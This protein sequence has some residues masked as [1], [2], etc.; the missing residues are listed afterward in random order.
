MKSNKVDVLA[1]VSAP[2]SSRKNVTVPLASICTKYVWG[3]WGYCG[4]ASCSVRCHSWGRL[5]GNL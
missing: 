1:E 5:W 3:Q 4:A 2:V